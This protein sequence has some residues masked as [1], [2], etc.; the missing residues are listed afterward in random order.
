MR[1]SATPQS[2][3]GGGRK[4]EAKEIPTEQLTKEYQAR[5]D[6]IFQIINSKRADSSG[7]IS[8]DKVTVKLGVEAGGK[9]GW[10]VEGRLDVS[11]AFEVEFKVSE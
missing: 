5:V 6:E 11:F 4:P 9:I 8:V 7:K 3:F 2:I 10:F 1:R